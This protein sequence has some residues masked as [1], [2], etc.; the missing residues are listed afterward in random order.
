MN[1]FNR[2]LISYIDIHSLAIKVCLI[3]KEHNS[4][5]H[6]TLNMNFNLSQKDINFIQPLWK[7]LNVFFITPYYDFNRKVTKYWVFSKLFGSVFILARI[8]WIGAMMQNEKEVEMW[9]SLLF[10]QKFSY[11]FSMV[12]LI[13]LNLI[14][15]FKSS[16]LVNIKEWEFLFTNLQYID[17]EFQNKGKLERRV[18]KNFSSSFL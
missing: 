4:I 8:I 1:Q 10:T 6:L 12:T 17:M 2:N 18:W 15:M 13:T 16:F 9:S 5:T 7:F 3:S 14:T 11:I